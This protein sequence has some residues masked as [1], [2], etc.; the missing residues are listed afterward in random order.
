MRKSPIISHRSTL[1]CSL[2]LANFFGLYDVDNKS[3][4]KYIVF[5]IFRMFNWIVVSQM[6]V[7]NIADFFVNIDD[8][9]EVSYNLGF[10]FALITTNF[11]VAAIYYQRTRFQKLIDDIHQPISLLKYSSGQL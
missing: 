11:K 8:L 2:R 7:A 3:P 10:I 9:L 6:L 1:D 5:S 4:V